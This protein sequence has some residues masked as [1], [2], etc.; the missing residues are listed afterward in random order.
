MFDEANAHRLLCRVRTVSSRAHTLPARCLR[1]TCTL[2]ELVCVQRVVRTH[3]LPVRVFT[4]QSD[5][6]SHPRAHPPPIRW[7][8]VFRESFQTL[9]TP[10]Y[11]LGYRF[12][13]PERKASPRLLAVDA[14][15][16]AEIFACWK[17]SLLAVSKV[18]LSVFKFLGD[19]QSARKYLNLGEYCYLL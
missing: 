3:G 19:T 5:G 1:C 17:I 2:R 6:L 18:Q 13:L 11:C 15:T 12:A 8:S 10:R 16:V 7:T 14:L 9:A 4:Y